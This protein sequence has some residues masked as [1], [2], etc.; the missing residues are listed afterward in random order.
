[1]KINVT[2]VYSVKRVISKYILCYTFIQKLMKN[3]TDISSQRQARLQTCAAFVGHK[4]L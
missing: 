4:G 3:K 1:M 2:I